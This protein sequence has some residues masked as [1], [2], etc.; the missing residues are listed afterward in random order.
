[1]DAPLELLPQS[2]RPPDDA[3]GAL[4]GNKNVSINELSVR[5]S[6]PADDP[7][8]EVKEGSRDYYS[9]LCYRARPYLD[10]PPEKAALWESGFRDAQ[11]LDQDRV[12]RSYCFPNR[13]AQGADPEALRSVPAPYPPIAAGGTAQGT[14]S[15]EIT[16]CMRDTGE[17]RSFCLRANPHPITCTGLFT[18]YPTRNG[19][20]LNDASSIKG[21]DA[22]Y[23]CL[24]SWGGAGHSPF[25]GLC[26][27]NERCRVVGTYRR[28]DGKVY[29]V[30]YAWNSAQKLKPRTPSEPEGPRTVLAPLSPTL[31][32][33][34]PPVT[35]LR[36]PLYLEGGTFTVPVLINNKLMLDFV[37]DSGAADVSIPA[38]VVMTLM[39]TGTISDAD[40]LGKQ[41]YRLADGRT[42]PS[43]T[44]RIKSLTIAD[45]IIE[46]LTGSVAPVEGHLLLGK[47]FSAVS[48]RGQSTIKGKFSF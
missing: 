34:P 12:D 20:Y 27:D 46:N 44:F 5:A 3:V 47:A 16:K 42:V 14:D 24:I 1:V 19:K 40:F 39:R 17:S 36:I 38:D 25:R 10:G 18:D 43:E 29:F 9:G 15:A 4:P 28:K 37:L 11:R 6:A 7:Y 33:D 23:T 13:A 21:E 45:R 2:L 30:D 26:F 41:T 48:N 31:P 8:K 32:A 22:D 35:G